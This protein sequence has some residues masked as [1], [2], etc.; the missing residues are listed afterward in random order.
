MGGPPKAEA[1]RHVTKAA[2]SLQLPYPKSNDPLNAA[3]QTTPTQAVGDG[4]GQLQPGEWSKLDSHRVPPS[5]PAN[6]SRG[7]MS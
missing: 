5:I 4:L 2:V 6:L 7:V 3:W 1:A